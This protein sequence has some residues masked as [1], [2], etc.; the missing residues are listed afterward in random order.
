MQHHPLSSATAALAGLCLLC[1]LVSGPSV[2][3]DNISR[4][5][6]IAIAL[7]RNGGAGK[8]LGVRKVQSKNGQQVYAVKVLT[9][10]RVKV[11]R[12]GGS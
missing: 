7:E 11:Y 3:A 8:V 12:V 1:A 9:N 2:A 6:A 5:Q 10:G 4:E